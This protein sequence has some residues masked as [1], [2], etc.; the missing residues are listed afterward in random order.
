[1]QSELKEIHASQFK[2]PSLSNYTLQWSRFEWAIVFEIHKNIQVSMPSKI[3]ALQC[4]HW[5]LNNQIKNI[6]N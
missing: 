5:S 2:D 6:A 3:S 1:M 4:S